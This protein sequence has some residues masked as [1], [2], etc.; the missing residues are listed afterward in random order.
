MPDTSPRTDADDPY[1]ALRQLGSRAH[2]L[3]AT[4]RAADHFMARDTD[5]DRN[6]G[7]WLMSSAL[8]MAGELAADIDVLARNLRERPADA[9]LQQ[10]VSA[11]R[12]R[13]HQLSAAARAA[14]HFLDQDTNEDRDTGGWLIATAQG[15][16]H[17]LASEIDD[18]AA[19]ARR[20][21]IDKAGGD[22]HDPALTRRM[23]AATAPLRGAA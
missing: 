10:T 2:Q 4:T 11:L 6:T 8:V 1:H 13:A 19:P 5:D 12:V 14:D 16:A 18:G 21:S 7:S 3:R 17:K 20:P 9:A 15:L 23:A 22:P